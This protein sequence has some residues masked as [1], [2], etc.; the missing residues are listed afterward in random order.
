[1]V[2]GPLPGKDGIAHPV[3]HIG[4]PRAAI[5]PEHAAAAGHQQVRRDGGVGG[6]RVVEAR[7][8]VLH[9]H[10]RLAS[11][12]DGD[13]DHDLR[14]RPQMIAVDGRVGER[15][16]GRHREVGPAVRGEARALHRGEDALDGGGDGR[17]EAGHAEA[18]G[19]CL[20]LACPTAQGRHARTP[21]GAGHRDATR[22]SNRNR[23]RLPHRWS[24]GQLGGPGKRFGSG[25]PRGLQS[26]P[27]AG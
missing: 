9:F 25:D 8:R 17:P 26:R 3:R 27:A 23:P 21:L 2:A 15:L 1:M 6:R 24:C 5:A 10:R 20:G 16:R 14:A 13:R 11:G 7:P 22:D 4:D 18:A 12:D 19:T